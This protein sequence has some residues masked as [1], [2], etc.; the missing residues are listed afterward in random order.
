MS[1]AVGSCGFAMGPIEWD[2]EKEVFR[3]RP[4]FS[5][6]HISL[7]LVS[8]AGAPCQL[9]VA[10]LI[11]N[12]GRPCLEPPFLWNGT[13]LSRSG[14][15]VLLHGPKPAN[16]RQWL[17]WRGP[18]RLGSCVVVR[19]GG[20][21]AWGNLQE[22]Q[23]S[24][25]HVLQAPGWGRSGVGSHEPVCSIGGALVDVLRHLVTVGTGPAADGVGD[26]PG[27]KHGAAWSVL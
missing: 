19:K 22:M 24:A 1:E 7:Q 26:C 15:A 9:T 27:G 6:Q 13:C 2:P 25:P 16:R 23:A 14:R 18:S 21:F 10:F 17:Q 12:S 5:I 11:T 8:V 4:A 3:S 20:L